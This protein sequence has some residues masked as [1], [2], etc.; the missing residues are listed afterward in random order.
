MWIWTNWIIIGEVKGFGGDN[1]APEVV[2]FKRHK[3]DYLP[4]EFQ[5][6]E[7]YEGI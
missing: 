6:K 3:G 5:K 2:V 7:N 4:E 1:P